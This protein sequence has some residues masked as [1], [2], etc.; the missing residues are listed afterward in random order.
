ML[1]EDHSALRNSLLSSLLAVRLHNQ[2]QRTGE[3]RLFEIGRVFIPGE[4]A[5]P[6]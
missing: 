3:A 1:R 2:N 6:G 4:G 5:A